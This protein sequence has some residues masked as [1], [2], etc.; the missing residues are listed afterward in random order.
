MGGEDDGAGALIVKPVGKGRAY[1]YGS[2][3]TEQAVEVFLKRFGMAEPYADRITVPAECEIA[4]R[5]KDGERYLFVLNYDAAPKAVVL[6][7]RMRDLY[8]GEILYGKVQME[9]YGTAV[10]QVLEN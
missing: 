3:F 1:Y 4:V 8:T 5:V 9:K 2:A 6:H 7:V 10:L